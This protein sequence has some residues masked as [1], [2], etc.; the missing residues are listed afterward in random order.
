VR[1]QLRLF[2]SDMQFAAF[3]KVLRNRRQR[4]Y[5]QITRRVLG[6]LKR[7]SAKV[8]KQQTVAIIVAVI[9]PPLGFLQVQ[10]E[11]I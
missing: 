8:K 10:K 6:S 4:I 7:K 2:K 9:E 5:P 11:T 3:S 1:Q